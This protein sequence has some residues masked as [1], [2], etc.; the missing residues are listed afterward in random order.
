MTVV[1]EGPVSRDDEWADWPT[2][3]REPYAGTPPLVWYALEGGAA[4]HLPAWDG[5]VAWFTRCGKR[6]ANMA[7][8]TPA[9]A[10]T[11]AACV[12]SAV[13]SRLIPKRTAG[14]LGLGGTP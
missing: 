2:Q 6:I 14:L 11:C 10:E 7:A 13:E 5:V 3:R 4:A 8:V 12:R 9:A 1:V